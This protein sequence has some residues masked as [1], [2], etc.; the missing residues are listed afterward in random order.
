MQLKKGGNTVPNV[1]VL[2]ISSGA[3]C[4]LRYD[5]SIWIGNGA[6]AISVKDV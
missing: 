1:V 6:E 4:G 3:N 2:R 5:V